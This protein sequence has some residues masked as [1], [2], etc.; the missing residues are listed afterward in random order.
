MAKKQPRPARRTT[1][2]APAPELQTPAAA[3]ASPVAPPLHELPLRR[4]RVKLQGLRPL[5]L[6]PVREVRVMQDYLDVSAADEADA[7]EQFARYNGIPWVT[8]PVTGARRLGSI[9]T[10]E[11]QELGN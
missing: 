1:Q 8:D 4:F 5:V 7:V 6:D 11:V 10:P 3:D 2:A 9:H